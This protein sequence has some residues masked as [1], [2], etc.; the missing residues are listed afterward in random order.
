MFKNH[1]IQVYIKETKSNKCMTVIKG[2]QDIY[3][4]KQIARLLTSKLHC[5]GTVIKDMDLDHHIKLNG[6]QMQKVNEFLELN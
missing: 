4:A 5:G 1:K 2:F 6:N 3:E